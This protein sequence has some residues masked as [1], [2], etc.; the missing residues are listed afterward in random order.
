MTLFAILLEAYSYMDP[1]PKT[2]Q[3]EDVLKSRL[4]MEHYDKVGLGRGLVNQFTRYYHSCV[5]SGFQLQY[6]PQSEGGSGSD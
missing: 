2:K 5:L 6:F 1:G 4:A 3:E